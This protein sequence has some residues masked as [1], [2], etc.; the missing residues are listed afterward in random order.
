MLRSTYSI[1]VRQL[2]EAVRL[3][4][5]R[6]QYAATRAATKTAFDVRDALR[7]QIE[8]TFFKP[9]RFVINNVRV[10]QYAKKAQPEAV[11]DIARTF[12]VRG[13]QVEDIYRTQIFGGT[14]QP[15]QAEI[16]IGRLSPGG[17]SIY[18]MPARF[19]QYDSNGNP[20][21]GELTLILSQLGV[22]NRGDNRAARKAR[23]SRKARTQY[24]VI[25]GSGQ[26]FNSSG[27]DLA[28]G[29]YRRNDAGRALPV[30]MFMKGPPKYRRRLDWFGTAERTVRASAPRHFREAMAR[31]NQP[32]N[33]LP[34]EGAS[35]AA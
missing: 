35:Q 14:R 20:N 27:S 11:V 25:W 12:G 32:A 18:M 8:T 10:T 3:V 13:R 5:S 7:K 28:P 33:D 24:F 15:K 2:Q 34:A 26:G 21:R 19:A 29:I 9:T 23:R 22:L 30:Y 16:R 6:A 1:D 31:G 17:Q 4:R